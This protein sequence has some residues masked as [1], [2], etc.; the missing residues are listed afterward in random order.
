MSVRIASV[1]LRISAVSGGVR[2]SRLSAGTVISTRDSEGALGEYM[3]H[4]EKPRA[5]ITC[6][7]PAKPNRPALPVLTSKR[8]MGEARYTTESRAP[9][10]AGAGGGGAGGGGRGGAG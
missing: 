8:L 9:G 7:W 6:S 5:R 10:W 2:T 4:P 1:T 3:T